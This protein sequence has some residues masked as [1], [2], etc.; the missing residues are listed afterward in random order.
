MRV[1]KPLWLYQPQEDASEITRSPDSLTIFTES[2]KYH[3]K[4][5]LRSVNCT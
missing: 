3:I 4:E 5:H 2:Y 1:Q